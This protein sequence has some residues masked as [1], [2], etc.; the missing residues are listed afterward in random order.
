MKR[1]RPRGMAELC[2]E[3]AQAHGWVPSAAGWM[4]APGEPRDCYGQRM[5][6]IRTSFGA[7]ESLDCIAA[8]LLPWD[9]SLPD[10]EGARA[11][12]LAWAEAHGLRPFRDRSEAMTYHR[13]IPLAEAARR[14]PMPDEQASALLVERGLTFTSLH[15]DVVTRWGDVLDALGDGRLAGRP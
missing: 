15:G 2:V 10:R 9:G 14:L 5:H 13:L 4:T 7:G 8:V 11:S 3:Y 1:L 6:S 12:V